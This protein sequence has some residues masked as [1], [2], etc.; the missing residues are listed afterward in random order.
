MVSKYKVKSIPGS[1]LQSIKYPITNVI[2]SYPLVRT[3]VE[4]MNEKKGSEKL[5]TFIVAMFFLGALI[6]IMILSKPHGDFGDSFAP[7]EINSWIVLDQGHLEDPA[8]PEGLIILGAGRPATLKFEVFNMDPDN[9]IDTIDVK[10]P[11]SE[12]V[13]GSYEWYL[14]EGEHEWSNDV[15][16]SDT[17]TFEAQDDFM[18]SE[19]GELPY[20]D[21]AGN[22][23]DA[24]DF[25]EDYNDLDNPLYDLSEGI[26]L[27]V[28][29]NTTDEPG[30]KMGEDSINLRVGD[31]ITEVPGAPLTSFEPFPYPYIAAE[32]DDTYLIIVLE[33]MSCHL[34]IEY[35]EEHL[36]S[37][38][39]G[40]D[41]RISQYGFEYVTESGATVAALMDP[42]TTHVKPL[43]RAKEDGLTGQ[44][45]L[46]MYK[47]KITDIESGSFEKITIVN[48]YQDDIPS[49]MGEIVDNDLDDD[50]ILNNDDDDMDGDEIP[51][52]LD[53]FPR[54]Y[55][56]LPVII[57]KSDNLTV[58][59][60]E[61]FT[62]T[63]DANDPESEILTYSWTND[64]DQAWTATGK[65]LDLTGFEPGDYIFSVEITDEF[66]NTIT[67]SISVTILENLS[68][69]ILTVTADNT[70]I[71]EGDEVTLSAN[72]SDPE[73]EVLTY[74]W[75]NNIDPE[76][77]ETGNPININDLEKGDYIFTVTVTDGWSNSTGTVQITVKEE[78]GGLPWIPI[79]IATVIILIIIVIALVL[80]LRNK[81]KGEAAE[82]GIGA[83]D[84]HDTGFG[85]TE[86]SPEASYEHFHDPNEDVSVGSYTP[87]TPDAPPVIYPAESSSAVL[88]E[89]HEGAAEMEYPQD[90]PQEIMPGQTVETPPLPETTTVEPLPAA[91][92][93]EP[94]PVEGSPAITPPPD[95][96]S[97]PSIPVP[98][99]PI[100]EFLKTP[101]DENAE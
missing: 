46:D 31:L 22:V 27:S 60:N 85:E 29:F 61:I 26:T 25:I 89:S 13:S 38:T 19:G 66:G 77:K 32:N 33:T 91:S 20:Y 101:E 18:G 44:F 73:A 6:A 24:L 59:E 76:W 4:S 10:I 80:V 34:E 45:V 79:I 83:L 41:F 92:M 8:I 1:I 88:E 93:Q 68:P 23:D 58:K 47:I 7:G 72:A 48:D 54:I 53:N 43:V 90:I 95:P 11:D 81:R 57:G 39:R 75:T 35:G 51:N 62:L 21:T 69:T 99:P 9:D 15:M 78:E 63:V 56:R 2:S 17:I 98:P 40:G 74:I 64:K 94:E 86:M 37:F 52:S 30:F 65:S 100:P 49:E 12:I 42:G 50:S 71:T 55:N 87:D 5:A 16:E 3:G 36:F 82:E 28:S 67:E 70:E 84:T 14:P 97:I 96:P